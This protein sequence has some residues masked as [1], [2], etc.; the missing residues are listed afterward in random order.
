M[1]IARNPTSIPG[2]PELADAAP[3]PSAPDTIRRLDYQP[4]A[5]LVPDI[6]LEFELGTEL[7]K[8]R[9]TLTVR[10]NPDASRDQTL[11]LC[12]DNIAVMDLMVDG[13]PAEGWSM[14]GSNLLL[15]LPGDAHEVTIET[16]LHPATN[17]QLMGLYASNG[18]LCTQCEAEG[19]RRITFFPDRPDV[20]SRY[21]VRMSGP[22]A[23]F[24]I[25]L[26]NG[27]MTASGEKDDGTH[28]A[29]WTD[30][31][32][33]PS[34]LFALVAGDL[35]ARKDSFTTMSGR[36]VELGVWVRPGDE[37]R[38]EHAMRSLINS[39]KCDEEVF[40]R[41]YDLDTFNIV[42]VSDFNMCA[43]ENKGLNIFNTALTL[44]KPSTASMG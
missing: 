27:D 43:M 3:E 10:Q 11:H 39:M 25:L 37:D 6:A 29:E 24:P 19:F 22:K 31:W 13:K 32:P 36:K 1:D 9:S 18:M 23:D 30:P 41:E 38:T 33:K 14:S 4:P 5:W 28:W 12:G 17:S 44:A 42:A 35:V 8:V 15:P 20:L 40:G 26:S 2:N 34:Y 21:S 7:T 16:H